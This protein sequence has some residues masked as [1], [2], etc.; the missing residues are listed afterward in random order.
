MTARVSEAHSLH[1]VSRAPRLSSLA[2][3]G[4]AAAAAFCSLF[5]NQ[6]VYFNTPVTTDE[7]SYVFQANTFLEGRIARPCPPIPTVFQHEMIIVDS[8]AGWVSRYP[9]AHSLW[10]VPG[11]WLDQP[12][13]MVALAAGLSAWF[14]SGSVLCLGGSALAVCL[15]LLFSPFFQFM[16]G[17]LLSHT[18]GLMAVS[19]MWWAYV[20]WQTGGRVGFAAVAGLAWAVLFLNRTYTG[21]LMALPLGVDAMVR[22]LL[23]WRQRSQWGGTVLFGLFALVGVGAYLFY[24][25][26]ALGDPFSSTYLYYQDRWQLGFNG[27]HRVVDGLHTTWKNILLLD[28]WLWGMSGSLLIVIAAI[29]IGWSTAWTP[30][31]V[32]CFLAVVGGYAAFSFPGFNT[33]GPYYYFETLPFLFTLVG[34]AAARIRRWRFGRGLLVFLAFVLVVG[35]LAFMKHE[36][37][38]TRKARAEDTLAQ[39]A[40]ANAPTNA[41]VFVGGFEEEIGRNLLLN[42]RG[43][44]SD[45]LVVPNW[46]TKNILVAR[47]FP[48]RTCYQLRPGQDHVEPYTLTPSILSYDIPVEDCTSGTGSQEPGD[49]W[50]ADAPRTKAG[51]LAYGKWM[52]IVAGR[53]QM[54]FRLRYDGVTPQAPLRLEVVAE[55]DGRRVVHH[56]LNG[57]TNADTTILFDMPEYDRVEPRIYYGGSGRVVFK[58][59]RMGDAPAVDM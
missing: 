52:H 4:F 55:S 20:R 11:V 29:V 59:F 56:T 18:S 13:L 27:D 33:C 6:F 48:E 25:Y 21:T 12:R 46:G 26:L 30:V 2:R 32:A 45:P 38:R 19:V 14:I 15:V 10:L 35:S 40:L 5:I 47:T 9:P 8:K 24:N 39:A 51:Y 31:C 22:L 49:T 43:L 28:R 54:V 36:A 50:V 17:T 3:F 53:Y 16:Y 34:L 44:R 58:G 23:H 42:D 57:A 7:N 1:T 41:L 37:K